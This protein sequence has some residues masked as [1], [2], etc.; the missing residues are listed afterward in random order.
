M[1]SGGKTN[2][3]TWVIATLVALASPGVL[4]ACGSGGNS[5]SPSV[6]KLQVV[7]AENFWGSI[8]SQLGGSKVSVQSI[9][10]NPNTDPHSYEPTA[11]DARTLASAK[12]AMV[13]GIGYDTWASHLL[14]ANPVSGR[15]TLDVG[16]LLGLKEGDNPHQWYSPES[17][18][19]VVHTVVADYERLDPADK[20]YFAAQE[21]HFETVSLAAY[22]RLRAEIRRRFAGVPVGY[23]ES[24]FQPLGQALGLKLL[25]PYSFAK[26]VAEGTEINAQD[27]QTVDAQAQRRLIKVWVYNSQNATPD[28]QRINSI[29][30]ARHIPI[31]TVTETLAPASDSFEQWQVA[32]LDSL[33]KALHYATRR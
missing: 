12:L 4:A 22:N 6:G 17:V 28:I 26:A 14:A 1:R 16:T 23:S 21:R 32:E 18:Q 7:A 10:V 5:S 19:K 27:K 25:T 20:A 13:N 8:A 15:T 30:R 31:A 3:R 2:V 24:I 11:S 33:T 29:C 9:I